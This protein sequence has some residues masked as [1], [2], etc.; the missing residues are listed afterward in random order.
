MRREL[1]STAML[2][3]LVGVAASTVQLDLPSSAKF[4]L[5]NIG[6]NVDPVLPPANDSCVVAIAFEPLVHASI[7]P[8]PR[9]FVVPAAVS[10]SA[11]L[12]TMRLFD[13]NAGQSSS[14]L[15]ASKGLDAFVNTATFSRRVVPVVPMHIGKLRGFG[16]SD[17][18]PSLL[19]AERTAVAVRSTAIHSIRHGTVVFED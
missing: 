14:L 10:D 11:S 2:A 18:L 9:L 15:T 19:Y 12:S 13:K 6:S 4:V 8:A 5:L 3:A 17:S 7:P 16:S 1:I